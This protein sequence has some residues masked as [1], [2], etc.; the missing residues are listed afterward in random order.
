MY[1]N[2]PKIQYLPNSNLNQEECKVKED[3]D[4]KSPIWSTTP[5]MVY[6]VII[7]LRKPLSILCSPLISINEMVKLITIFLNKFLN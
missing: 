5:T 7:T 6:I 3:K 1:L 2:N 4:E